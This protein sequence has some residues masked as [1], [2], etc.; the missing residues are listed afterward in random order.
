MNFKKED[1]LFL[2]WVWHARFGEWL[3]NNM[4]LTLEEARKKACQYKE[5]G[6]DAVVLFWRGQGDQYYHILF[7]R[8]HFEEGQD[9]LQML[10][11]VVAIIV[12][13]C[14]ENEIKV[15]EH[16]GVAF[17]HMDD[18]IRNKHPSEL[19][20]KKWNLG[21]WLAYNAETGEESFV[22]QY[23]G[24][25]FCPNNPKYLEAYRDYVAD[26]ISIGT[27]GL[28]SDDV[29][30]YPSWYSCGCQYC[31]EKFSRETGYNLPAPG[32]GYGFWENFDNPAWR[33]W[34]K[35]RMKSAGD[36][37]INIEAQ[38]TK[39]GLPLLRLA[40]CS[41]IT[42]TYGSQFYGMSYEE[43]I[44][45]CNMIHFENYSGL[46][47]C[48]CWQRIG[49]EAKVYT[50]LGKLYQVPIITMFY[51]RNAN[52]YFFYWALTKMWGHGYW[53]SETFAEGTKDLM[54]SLI[55]WEKQNQELFKRGHME[56][57][58]SIAVVFSKQT[59]DVYKGCHDDYYVNE[60]AGWCETLLEANLQFDVL[61]DAD[62]NMDKL[63]KYELLILANVACLSSK[64]LNVIEEFVSNGGNL[65]V[66]HETSL[67][68]ETGERRD[69][70]GLKDLLGLSYQKTISEINLP[71]EINQK[72]C[73]QITNGLEG[74]IPHNAPQVVVREHEEALDNLTFLGYL[75]PII[76]D[77]L[78]HGMSPAIVEASYEE[79]K[80]P[81]RVVYLSGKPGLMHYTPLV[82]DKR[83]GG[84]DPYT[85]MAHRLPAYK[86]LM[87]N[88][89]QELASERKMI[90]S[91]AP[92]GVLI[93][94]Q[95][96]FY[97]GK[98]RILVHILN[99]AG[100]I[101]PTNYEI[102]QDVQLSYP[103]FTSVSEKIEL[104]LALDIISGN[105]S[106]IR[107]TLLSPDL[108]DDYFLPIEI[109]GEKLII[110][111]LAELV[112]RYCM[113]VIENVRI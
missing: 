93:E 108:E 104:T 85:N 51:P 91:K 61:L 48:F 64:Q 6:I 92:N 72:S 113:V 26:V 44:R 89:V 39:L 107:A 103:E 30:F 97:Q 14:H 11:N 81:G 82:Y 100:T 62:M 55:L 19:W 101:L 35:F 112:H 2:D 79:S 68:D 13:A 96:Q 60:W 94:G 46:L 87:E 43:Y 18:D 109:K 24:K 102:P 1:L 65:L 57:L 88:I 10:N 76:Y 83:V 52:E 56:S 21:E 54:G 27:D 5:K 8:A 42:P 50:A 77:P 67:Y 36:F 66:T 99:T 86:R 105:A 78:M 4:D 20:Y 3:V 12:K 45:G 95:R 23:K 49:A 63:R 75:N 34:L 17:V 25:V 80:C 32:Q 38:V 47:A 16:H 33:A 84:Q 9:T 98:S 29:V 71:F 15:I 53:G 7:D 90:V 31:R 58:S 59:R 22:K 73:S 111:I 74:L 70:F 40:C 69:D 110:G 28:M 106:E 41:E 37:H